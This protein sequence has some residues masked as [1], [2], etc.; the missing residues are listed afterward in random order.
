MVIATQ[1]RPERLAFLAA[2]HAS[3]CRQSV[4]WEAVVALDG[5]DPTRLP[6]ALAV[7]P[8]IRTLALPRSVGAACARNFALNEVRTEYVQWADDDDEFTDWA[9]ALRL[10][11]LE[12]TGV[13]WCAGYSQTPHVAMPSSSRDEPSVHGAVV[14]PPVPLVG[15]GSGVGGQDGVW[16]GLDEVQQGPGDAVAVVRAEAGDQRSGFLARDRLRNR[17]ELLDAPV[18]LLFARVPVGERAVGDER[19]HFG[20]HG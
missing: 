9:M 1:L 20:S 4:P 7:D 18:D 14:E 19:L 6:A 11:T 12:E 17:F 3:L 16:A 5:A 15:V 13:G 2:M 10:R 8:R